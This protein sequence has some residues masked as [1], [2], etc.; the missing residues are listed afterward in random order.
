LPSGI[1][2]GLQPERLKTLD[3]GYGLW[4]AKPA[5]GQVQPLA[6]LAERAVGFGPLEHFALAKA[7]RTADDAHHEG[8]RREDQVYQRN[9][10]RDERGSNAG[11]QGNA[12]A[13]EA[14]SRGEGPY[15]H[16]RR[17][18]WTAE[19]AEGK[20]EG[21]ERHDRNLSRGWVVTPEGWSSVATL[22]PEQRP[23]LIAARDMSLDTRPP[24][25]Y[26]P[27]YQ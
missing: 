22:P 3:A 24:T 13:T 16:L 23:C 2:V 14:F 18:G 20:R 4:Q 12:R 10:E 9:R 19:A 17:A 8:H 1:W 7:P 5:A 11:S 6:G 25:R 26:H 21:S 27:D 15:H